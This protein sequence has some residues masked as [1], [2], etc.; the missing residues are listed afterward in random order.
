VFE[1]MMVVLEVLV[2]IYVCDNYVDG[3]DLLL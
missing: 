2:K 1:L 3:D